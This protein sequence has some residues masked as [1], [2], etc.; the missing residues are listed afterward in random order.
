MTMHYRPNLVEWASDQ[1]HLAM[2]SATLVDWFSDIIKH[3][4]GKTSN[5]LD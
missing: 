5:C 1:G 3:N 2:T 4:H